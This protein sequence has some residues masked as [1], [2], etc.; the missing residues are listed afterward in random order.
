MCATELLKQYQSSFSHRRESLLGNLAEH[1]LS[2]EDEEDLVPIL[3][4]EVWRYSG[5]SEQQF[6]DLA[7]WLSWLNAL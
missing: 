2:P 6:T 3:E 5:Q 1:G 4:A 7:A